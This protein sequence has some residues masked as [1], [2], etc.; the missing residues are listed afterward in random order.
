MSKFVN[1]RANLVEFRGDKVLFCLYHTGTIGHYTVN[2]WFMVIVITTEN[3]LVR[4]FYVNFHCE[5]FISRI[6]V[7]L[8]GENLTDNINSRI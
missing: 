7:I 3:K 2:E 4:L 8:L 6:Q 1:F 5:S